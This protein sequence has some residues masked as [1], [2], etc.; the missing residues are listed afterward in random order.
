[1]DMRTEPTPTNGHHTSREVDETYALKYP[2]GSIDPISVEHYKEDVR[3]LISGNDSAEWK[4]LYR[5]GFRV[6]KVTVKEAK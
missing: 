4:K 5:Q 3:N 2:D 6:V 1:M